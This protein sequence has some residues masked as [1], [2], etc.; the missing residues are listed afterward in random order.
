MERSSGPE[1]IDTDRLPQLTDELDQYLAQ[2]WYRLRFPSALER[3][4]FQTTRKSRFS[5]L[6]SGLL[7]LALLHAVLLFPDALQ[8][9]QMFMLGLLL[10]GCISVPLLV[11]GTLILRRP[12]P[13]WIETLTAALPLLVTFFCDEQIAR[14]AAGLHADRYFMGTATL[15]FISAVLLPFRRWDGAVYMLL[16]LVTYDVTLSGA[17]GPVPF[18]RPHELSVAVVVY[19]FTSGAIRLRN[20]AHERRAFV[21]AERDRISTKQ[22]A[23]ANRQLTELSYTDALTGLAN[24]RFFDEALLRLWNH[25]KEMH[26]PLSVLMIDIDHFKRFN[27]SLGHAAGDKCLRRVAQAM[28]FCVRA[29]KDSL[30]RCGGEEFIAII[31]GVTM[32][33]AA[34]IAERIRVAV[35]DLQ[36]VHPSN[37]LSPSVT[38]CVGVASAED[39]SF[40]ERPDLLLNA[41]DFAL[42]T[43]KSRGRNC[44]AGEELSTL[45]LR[46][47]A[48]AAGSRFHNLAAVAHSVSSSS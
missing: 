47:S 33:E 4:F 37:P 38:V 22:L 25:S 40:L 15:M 1:R 43:A 3:R 19:L 34:Q 48:E 26:L 46:T 6:Q 11:I 5:H 10:R 16:N 45:P 2:P 9:H 23:W 30:A 7:V 31:P 29:D 35:E 44:V 20:E 27:D 18:A 13:R 17:F 8:G 24:R 41:A 21:L 36:I 39:A 28:Q 12:V 14:H 32:D 42:Y